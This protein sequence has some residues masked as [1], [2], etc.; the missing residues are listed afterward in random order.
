ME[1]FIAVLNYH[2]PYDGEW[3]RV[4]DYAYILLRGEEYGEFGVYDTRQG[5]DSAV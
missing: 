4:A 2:S 5:M 1:P 3:R